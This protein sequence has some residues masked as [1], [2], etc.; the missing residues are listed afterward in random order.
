MREIE[1]PMYFSLLPD[2]G[3]N[4]SILEAKGINGEFHLFRGDFVPADD[5]RTGNLTWGGY[6]YIE[7]MT[8]LDC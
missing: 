5:N 4:L 6:G 1:F 7:G 3:Y 2:P 8:L